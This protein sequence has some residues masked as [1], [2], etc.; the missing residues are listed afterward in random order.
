MQLYI[1]RIHSFS[2]FFRPHR[3]LMPKLSPLFQQVVIKLKNQLQIRVEGIMASSRVKTNKKKQE[4]NKEDCEQLG[5]SSSPDRTCRRSIKRLPSS[6]L[7]LFTLLP[8]FV[9]GFNCCLLCNDAVATV[10]VLRLAFVLSRNGAVQ[11]EF[12]EW[13]HEL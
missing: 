5:C 11:H 10:L 1:L 3:I 2:F 12:V 7:F 13:C 8:H 9:V 6:F 4:T